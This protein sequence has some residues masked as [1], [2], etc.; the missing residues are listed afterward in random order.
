M[1]IPPKNTKILNPQDYETLLSAL[2]QTAL[3]SATDIKG[4]IIYANQKFAEISKYSIDEMIGQNH[5]I[6]KSGHQPES[7]FIKLWQDISSGRVWRGEIKNRAKDGSYYWVDTSIAP[8]I[9]ENGK[10]ERYIS[11]RLL[12]T[13]LKR[14]ENNI[15]TQNEELAK[16][17]KA[18]LNIL[19]D[20]EEEKQKAQNLA[21][22][23]KKYELAVQGSSEHIIITNPDG[24]IVFANPAVEKITGFK[25]EETIGRKA[26]S[27]ELWGGLMGKNFYDKLWKTIK[28]DK[29]N[30][31][32]EVRNKRKNGEEYFA[33]STISPI[34]DSKNEVE[35]FVGI[36]RDITHEKEIDKAKTEFTSLASHQLRTP[37]SAINLYVEKLLTVNAGEI[38]P[39][40]KKFLEE[41]YQGGQRMTKLVNA[42]LNVSSIEIGTFKV[43][44]EENIDLAKLTQ[45]IINESKTIIEE[46][47]L[48][49]NLEKTDLPTIPLDPNLMTIILQNLLTNAVKY[50]HENGTIIIRLKTVKAGEILSGQKNAEDSFLIEVK[51]NGIGIPKSQNE[52][53]FNKLF[54]ADNARKSDTEGIGL[55]LYLVESLIQHCQG[56]IW[57]ES[58]ENIGTSFFVTIPTSGMKHKEGLRR[59]G[60]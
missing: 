55:G 14:I 25:R 36:E 39:E 11:I 6:F 26:G 7:I 15:R 28:I 43:E 30:F 18:M 5:R 23:L 50:T 57:F 8:I 40:Q 60:D 41:A 51:D 58:Q 42:L 44:P 32:G 22:E 1:E 16:T 10:I 27:K 46:K 33:L 31:T 19:E 35:F 47:K 48:K 34:I 12:I 53:I 20:I 17:N 56:K 45:T 9:G 4:T 52:L 29:K 3:V 2:D 59:L 54:R 21:H 37:L 38:N 13:D 24:I 49:V